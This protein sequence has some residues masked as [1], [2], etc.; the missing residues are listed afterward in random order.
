MLTRL[1]R[2]PANA[3]TAAGRQRRLATAARLLDA[4]E[5]VFARDGL[6][7]ATTR[8]IAQAA[9]VNEVTLFRHFGSK[10]RLLAAVLGRTFRGRP[11]P[12]SAEGGRGNLRAELAAFARR[13]EELLGE[14]LPLI[15][16]LIG[17]IH[18]H[19]ANER[20]VLHGIFQPTRAVLVRRLEQA[21]TAG[22]IRAGTDPEI[23]ADLLAG[24]IFSGVIRSAS[25][26]IVRPYS[27]AQYRES[28]VATFWAGI[29]APGSARA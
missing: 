4:A 25:P 23:A 11:A 8:S 18:R 27:P 7:G 3:R 13:Y 21:L 1:Q 17:E 15:R 16:T 10:E 29:A 26:L 22:E 19:R 5:R 6:Q 28:C 20:R 9:R 24:M 12:A 2:P 14:H